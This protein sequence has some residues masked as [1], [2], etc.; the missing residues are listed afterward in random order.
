[1]LLSE[2]V[3]KIR[4]DH[5]D[6]HAQPTRSADSTISHEGQIVGCKLPFGGSKKIKVGM[7]GV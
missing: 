6:W 5:P 7:I 1:M 3:F 4:A 2:F